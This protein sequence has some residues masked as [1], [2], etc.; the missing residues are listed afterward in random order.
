MGLP[1][2]TNIDDATVQQLLWRSEQDANGAAA[3]TAEGH[4]DRRKGRVLHLSPVC[5]HIAIETVN[6]ES[7]AAAA[8][9]S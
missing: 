1:L 7:P 6:R 2:A 4:S 3:L 9:R 5:T 8:N